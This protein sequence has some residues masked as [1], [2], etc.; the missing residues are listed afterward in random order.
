MVVANTCG[1]SVW[2]L[3]PS[4]FWHLELKDFRKFV[5]PW[6]TQSTNPKILCIIYYHH[7]LW[8]LYLIQSPGAHNEWSC[9]ELPSCTCT[10]RWEQT[11]S[12]VS[13]IIYAPNELRHGNAVLPVLADCLSKNI[14]LWASHG[15]HA[16]G[17]PEMKEHSLQQELLN[18]TCM[19]TKVNA[20]QNKH[21]HKNFSLRTAWHTDF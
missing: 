10:E 13:I 11:L 15:I 7:Q 14:T 3:P 12:S 18:C 8:Q 6:H 2:N 19:K 20:H 9:D 16:Q 21:L 5:D 4:P 1:Y 17:N